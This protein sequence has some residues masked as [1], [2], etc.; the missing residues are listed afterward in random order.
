ML[1]LLDE[2]QEENQEQKLYWG[3]TKYSYWKV[4]LGCVLGELFFTFYHPD[5]QWTVTEF[6]YK[7]WIWAHIK[8]IAVY[9][10]IIILTIYWEGI[11]RT[12]K[13]LNEWVEKI[14][15]LLKVM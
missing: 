5:I 13:K 12:T 2:K 3:L 14:V 7:S 10:F 1:D 6:S 15:L 4:I 11:L 9:Y 8:V